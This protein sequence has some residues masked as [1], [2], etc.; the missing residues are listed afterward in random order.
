MMTDIGIVSGAILN[1][2]SPKARQAGGA[3]DS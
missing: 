3:Y 2:P 1:L